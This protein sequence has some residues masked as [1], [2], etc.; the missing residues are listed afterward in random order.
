MMVE[1]DVCKGEKC[2]GH[3]R[4]GVRKKGPIAPACGLIQPPRR[5]ID[6][7]HYQA[8]H[9]DSHKDGEV[10]A[11]GFEFPLDVA[12]YLLGFLV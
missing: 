7:E 3:P 2:C 4:G 8:E 12:K 1:V 9:G 6:K 11:Q 10:Y 5:K